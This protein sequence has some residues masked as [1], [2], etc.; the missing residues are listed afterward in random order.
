MTT[1]Q[2]GYEGNLR[3]SCEHVKSGAILRTDAPVDNHGLGQGFS[4]TDLVATALGACMITVM[5]I[6]AESNSWSLEGVY[7]EVVKVM[8]DTPR[9]IEKIEV[10]ITMPTKLNDKERQILERTALNCPVAKSLAIELD[11]VVQFN[12]IA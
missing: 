4:P 11:Q 2:I 5:G 12:Y 8:G 3:T 9:R 10:H 1:V 7:C 6:K